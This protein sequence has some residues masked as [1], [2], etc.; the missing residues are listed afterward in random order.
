MNTKDYWIFDIDGTLAN[1]EHR[2]HHILD[3]APAQ[4]NWKSFYAESEKDTPIWPMIELLRIT[5]WSEIGKVILLTG[6]NELCRSDTEEWLF[7]HN[8]LYDDLIMRSRQDRR[9]AAAVKEY[10]LKKHKMTPENVYTIFDDDLSV[11]YH[12]RGLGYHV[13]DVAGG[14]YETRIQPL[15]ESVIEKR[16]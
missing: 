16:A 11:V 15:C 8:I 6:R 5:Y 13:C 9:C 1:A 4:K 3:K 10:K 2:L 12:L 14:N 7:R